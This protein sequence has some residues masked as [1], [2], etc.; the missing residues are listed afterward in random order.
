M[1]LKFII[2]DPWRRL[3]RTELPILHNFLNT[4]LHVIIR[5][6]TQEPRAFYKMA[7]GY[8]PSEKA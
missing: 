7:V 4:Y 2:R 1:V 3:F 8:K 6:L 5:Q